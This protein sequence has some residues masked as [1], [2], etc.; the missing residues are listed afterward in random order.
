MAT[1]GKLYVVE[2]GDQAH[3]IR[4]YTQRGATKGS[5]AP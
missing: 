3:L 2:L 5:S 1:P 4:A